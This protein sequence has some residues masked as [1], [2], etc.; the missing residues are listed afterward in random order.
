MTK[1][2]QRGR[3]RLRGGMDVGV[4][5]PVFETGLQ[6]GRAQL[7]AE[8]MGMAMMSCMRGRFNGAAL[9]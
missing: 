3:T 5:Y 4:Y 6:R 9:N 7:S 2:L 8:G 1:W